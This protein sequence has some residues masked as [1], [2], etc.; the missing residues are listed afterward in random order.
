MKEK[1][2]TRIA[3]SFLLSLTTSFV[4]CFLYCYIFKKG[5]ILTGDMLLQFIPEIENF[6]SSFPNYI[7]Y[8]NFLGSNSSF[9]FS[10]SCFSPFNILFYIFRSFDDNFVTIIVYSLKIAFAG[11]SF[12]LFSEK[13]LKNSNISSII[14]SLFYSF[15]SFSVVYGINNIMFLDSLIILPILIWGLL[16]CMDDGKRVLMIIAYSLL[17]ITQFHIGYM[18]GVFTFLFVLLY[19]FIYK[20]DNGDSFKKKL[21]VLLNYLIGVIISIMLSAFSWTP[22]LFYILANRLSSNSSEVVFPSLLQILNS[23][24]WGMGY[25]VRGECGYVYCGII[26]FVLTIAF[27]I[28]KNIQKKLKIFGI[29]LVCFVLICM[30]FEPM[31]L[32]MHAFDNPDFCYFRYSFLISFCACSMASIYIRDFNEI[33]LRIVKLASL[34]AIVFYLI[35]QLV[36]SNVYSKNSTD[37]ILNSNFGFII[38]ISF[39]SIWI[40]L[41]ALYNK[42]I[43]KIWLYFL[44]VISALE[45]CSNAIF[46]LDN[47]NY[48]NKY[49]SEYKNCV[50]VLI[51]TIKS[52][53]SDLYRIV[54]QNTEF[55][56]L[57]SYFDYAGI[58]DFGS[59]EKKGIR[60]LMSNIG[61]ETSPRVID[62]TEYNPVS[63]AILGV[64]YVLY[65]NNET[66]EFAINSTDDFV[67]M[68]YIASSDLIYYETSSRNAFENLNCIF[69]A[70]SGLD[71]ECFEI[72]DSDDIEY[73]CSNTY[74]N[75]T[76]GQICISPLGDDGY[77]K[78]EVSNSDNKYDEIY[79]QFEKD[80]PSREYGDYKVLN[81]ENVGYASFG[82]SSSVSATYKMGFDESS[83]KY[84]IFLKPVNGITS[85]FLCDSIN[86]YGF[87][88]S[89]F[90]KQCEIISQ[91]SMD[92]EEW[93]NG[94]LRGKISTGEGSRLLFFSIP[95]D[96]GWKA[97][98][99]GTEVETVRLIDGNFLGL[100]V[101][102]KDE[103]EIT[104]K[105]ECPG[106]KIG[107]LVSICGLLALAS[108]VFE[109]R[110]KELGKR[111]SEPGTK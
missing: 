29:A 28:D 61:F 45:V 8:S 89:V 93:D 59:G 50:N 99:N 21:N 68:S 49:I 60:Q 65:Y 64:K 108:V 46:I 73:I 109:N 3:I 23:F 79:M 33:R 92:I 100:F 30:I 52:E 83:N 7:N 6:Y 78:I 10:Y 42:N 37:L 1:I 103:C 81:A 98:A 66:G 84:V 58:S 31:N 48:N 74:F 75:D 110:I 105:Y 107:I 77:F 53:D 51:N 94:Y 71:E 106:L 86:V 19:I 17:F 12:Q 38:N 11:M 18:I 70:I 34:I 39:I 14:I 111:I 96:P 47:D 27:L 55:L 56:N 80:E 41:L 2:K 32:F 16:K 62:D 44:G 102:V 72:V 43:K 88:R 15:S 87:D 54:S 76:N 13:V 22:T 90:D 36:Y 20:F 67:G 40:L 24:F 9:V 35:M 57:D 85:D 91:K 104:L 101:P 4:F 5:N 97:Y 26:V 82:T 25:S 69:N 95:Y 63:N